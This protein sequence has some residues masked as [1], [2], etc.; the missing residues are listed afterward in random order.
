MKTKLVK[1]P[2]NIVYVVAVASLFH[3]TVWLINYIVYSHQF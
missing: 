1:N 2:L 3:A